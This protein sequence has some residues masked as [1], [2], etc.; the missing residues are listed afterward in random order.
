MTVNVYNARPRL[1]GL[2]LYTVTAANCNKLT[3]VQQLYIAKP[4]IR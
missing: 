4:A 2:A 1:V 3:T